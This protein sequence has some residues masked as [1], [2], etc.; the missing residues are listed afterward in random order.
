MFEPGN[1]LSAKG[2]Q[3]TRALERALAADNW[4]RLHRG[5]DKL[6]DAFAA[7]QPWALQLCFDRLEGRARQQIDVSSSD[8][9]EVSLADVVTAVMRA[10]ALASTDADPV[11]IEDR[12]QVET[13]QVEQHQARPIEQV[14]R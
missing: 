1:Q 4:A 2:K 10:R 7:G 9:R 13:L 8:I 3:V 12:V 11:Q 5:C 6:A 14:E